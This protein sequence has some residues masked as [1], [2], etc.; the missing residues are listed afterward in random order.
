MGT[1]GYFYM[2]LQ[3]IINGVT[4]YASAPML[5]PLSQLGNSFNFNLPAA[6]S[7]TV[8]SGAGGSASASP[9][10]GFS[11]ST[12]TLT[13]TPAAG[14]AFSSWVLNDPRGGVISSTGD[15]P[16]TFTFVGTNATVTANFSVIPP[17]PTGQVLNI[18]NLNLNPSGTADGLI[19][20][21]HGW[22]PPNAPSPYSGDALL[23][24]APHGQPAF[25]LAVKVVSR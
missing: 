17:T 16:A 23:P 10:S 25:D 13:A 7:I 14:H 1:S 12:T 11:G 3:N 22:T 4:Y 24:N 8:N 2:Q 5:I 18:P 20:V 15:N 21:I 9:T 6:C 19:L